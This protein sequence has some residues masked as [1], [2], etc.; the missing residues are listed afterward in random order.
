MSTARWLTLLAAAEAL[1]MTDT[2]LRRAIERHVRIGDA[3]IR[4]AAF[5]GIRARKFGG[6]WKVLL[7]PAWDVVASANEPRTTAS[8]PTKH[9]TRSQKD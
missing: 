4:E 1:A 9:A 6:R 7:G 5:N 2:A 8:S 3:G